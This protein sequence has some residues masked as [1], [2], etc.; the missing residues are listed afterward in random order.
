MKNSSENDIE[1]IG[2]LINDI[3]VNLD[4]YIEEQKCIEEEK[5][6]FEEGQKLIEEWREL[7]REEKKKEK[8]GLLKI[9]KRLEEDLESDE[10]ENLDELYEPYLNNDEIFK[11]DIKPNTT[12]CSL[13]FMFYVI[14]PAFSIINLVGI[15]ESITILKIIFKLLKNSVIYYYKYLRNDKDQLIIF[16]IQDFNDNYNFYYLFYE[17]TKKETFD[18]N[19]MMLNGFLGDIILKSKGFRVTTII[20]FIMNSISIFLIISFSFSEYNDD[21]GHFHFFKFYIFF[22]VGYYYS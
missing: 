18:F 17:D 16:S 22:Y 13:F 11:R 15:Y 8:L 20:F 21:Y 2:K 1:K 14:S 10:F 9:V 12:R 7:K 19:L 4:K 5:K 3:Q 6:R